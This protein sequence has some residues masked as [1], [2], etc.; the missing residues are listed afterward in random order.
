MRGF[1]SIFCKDSCVSYISGS[2]ED[3]G[4]NDSSQ[5]ISTVIKCGHCELQQMV[6]ILQSTQIQQA[7]GM[8][9]NNNLIKYRME[10]TGNYFGQQRCK[11][12]LYGTD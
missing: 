3:F 4:E 2:S 7:G 1:K 5:A 10:A 12:D 11:K 6:L 8:N 9:G